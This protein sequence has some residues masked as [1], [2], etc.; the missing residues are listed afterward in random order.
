MVES[1][2]NTNHLFCR[3][4]S[5]AREMSAKKLGILITNPAA[6]LRFT[7]IYFCL[8]SLGMVPCQPIYALRLHYLLLW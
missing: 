1:M 2:G 4:S 8:L 3:T 7:V 5:M 6:T